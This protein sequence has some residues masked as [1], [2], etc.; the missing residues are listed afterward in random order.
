M[1]KLKIKLSF[2]DHNNKKNRFKKYFINWSITLILID[3][4][5]S[6]Q[7]KILVNLIWAQQ[8]K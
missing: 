1:W 6:T 4:G 8:L 7:T 2:N 5:S 3:G